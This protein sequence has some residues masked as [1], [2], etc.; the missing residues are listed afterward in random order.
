MHPHILYAWE[1]R[2][3]PDDFYERIMVLSG[4]SRFIAKKITLI[5]LNARSYRSLVGAINLDKVQ[6]A[7]ANKTRTVPQ[8]ILYDELKKSGL[9][10]KDIIQSVEEAHPL[11]EKYIYGGAANRLMLEESEVMTSVLLRLEELGIP[12]LPV[13]DSVIIPRKNEDWVKHVM[14]SVYSRHTNFKIMVD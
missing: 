6:Q 10:L 14:E 12:A 2:Q 4:C 5:A 3:C 1:G 9:L 7:N 13:H 8:P 11:L